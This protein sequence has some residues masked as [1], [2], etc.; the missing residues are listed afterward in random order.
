M[1]RAQDKDGRSLADVLYM[2]GFD[3]SDAA[4]GQI[5]LRREAVKGCAHILLAST[6]DQTLSPLKTA[7][8]LCNKSMWPP[9]QGPALVP[10]QGSHV[11][12]ASVRGGR[13][14]PARLLSAAYQPGSHQRMCTPATLCHRAEA[15]AHAEQ[16]P[17]LCLRSQV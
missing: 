7:G 9:Q 12:S 8:V 14:L 4:V 6:D 3:G 15:A 13:S 1:L 16:T 5:A 2:H 17:V 10:R 11:F